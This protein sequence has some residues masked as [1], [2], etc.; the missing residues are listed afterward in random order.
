MKIVQGPD[1][2]TGGIVQGIDEIKKAL[3]KHAEDTLDQFDY[4]FS[5][6]IE[7]QE[8]EYDD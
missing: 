3:I 6:Y 1:F 5:D 7:Q 2:P 8:D 4:V